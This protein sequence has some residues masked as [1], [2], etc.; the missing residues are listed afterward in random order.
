MRVFNQKE[1][2]E[3]LK[4]AAENSHTGDESEGVGLTIQELERVAEEA[5][6]DPAEVN[7]AAIALDANRQPAE[8]S[9]WGGP[10]SFSE[11]VQRDHEITTAE[12][13]NMLVAIREFFQAKGDVYTRDSVFEWS[14]PRGTTNQAHVTALKEDGK[15][16]ISVVWTGPLTALPYYLPVPLVG[17]LSLPFASEFLGLG[18]VAGM[19]FVALTVGLSFAA[20]RWALRKNMSKGFAKLR[21]LA[22]TLQG[23]A[24]P[25]LAAD[26]REPVIVAMNEPLLELNEEDTLTEATETREARRVKE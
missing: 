7:K 17:I 12:W 24:T 2:A 8:T 13:E 4:T 1:T 21:N 15:T 3:I 5:G 26:A 14:S 16:K 20:G 25:S 11:Q 6:I 22:A 18:A 19:S 9:F 23:E 10:F